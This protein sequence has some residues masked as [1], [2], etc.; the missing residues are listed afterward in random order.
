[1]TSSAAALSFAMSRTAFKF[2]N[3]NGVVHL[4]VFDARPQ[5]QALSSKIAALYGIPSN[6]V[7]ISYMDE[8][9]D[10]VT[11]TSDPQL[12]W[13]YDMYD[14][15]PYKFTV[16]YLKSPDCELSIQVIRCRHSD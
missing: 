8:D 12:Q 5:W 13:F 10:I 6:D 1:M 15:T 14:L 3:A 7:G 9:H 4:A 11:L 16:Q 2:R